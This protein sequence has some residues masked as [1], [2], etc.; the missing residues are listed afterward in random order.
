MMNI[1][2][3]GAGKLGTCLGYALAHKGYRIQA[4]SSRHLSSSALSSKI[5]GQGKPLTDNI[6]AACEG[7]I[8]FLCLPDEEIVK[9]AEEL[10]RANL[11]WANKIVYHCSGLLSSRILKPLK[12]QGAAIASFHP[13]QSFSQKDAPATEFKGIYFGLEGDKKALDM[14]QKIVRQLEG[15]TLL[16]KEKDK[17]LYHA[18][19]S[20]ASNFFVVLLDMATA[21]LKQTGLSEKKILE[22]LLPLVE[23]TLRNV[24]K[25]D[26]KAALTGP[27]A[28]GD[29][30]SVQKHLRALE[31]FPLYQDL[32]KK[33][34]AH[35]LEIAGS[36]KLPRQKI[37]AL[38][39]M[40]G[41]K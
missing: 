19:C 36:E 24:N 1:S 21:L 14:A 33:L 12:D 31:K 29:L 23:G 41:H 18:A 38:K 40:L 7:K 16:L 35:A 37:R 15:H 11:C 8:I 13:I 10:F 22:C 5:I 3:I 17:A 32:Y 27:I 6:Q 4:L 25:F 30:K 2:I 39:K 9:V 20:I 26:T 34:A 28:R